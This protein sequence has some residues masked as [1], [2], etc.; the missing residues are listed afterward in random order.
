M[1]ATDET[2]AETKSAPAARGPA[3]RRR[4]ARPAPRRPALVTEFQSDA[5]EIEHR[6]PPRLARLTLYAVVALIATAI[7]WASVSHVDM[8]VVAQGK[9]ITTRPNLV[10]QPLE[11]SVIRDI[12]VRVGDR[13]RRGDVLATLDPT[14]SQAD[15][16]L[17]RNR[18]AAFDATI[19]RLRAELNGKVYVITDP[20]N[21]DEILQRKIF[22]QRK[23][24]YDAQIEDDD[25]QIASAQ[26]NLKTARDEEAVLVQRLDTT[27]SI[28][29]MRT[30][31]MNKEIGSK[32]NFLLSRDARLEVESNL[33]RIRGNIADD[34]HRVDKARA[35]RKVFAEEFLRKA[36]EELVDT[37][38]KRNSAAEDLKK[39]ELRRKL[40][41]LQAP[42]DATVLQ[43]ADRT[44]GS[45][46]REAETLFVLVPRDATLQAEV[47]VQ[48]RDIG[49][50][51]VG[52]S[53]RIKFEAFPF[54]KYGTAAGEVRVISED[55]FSPDPK[56]ETGRRDAAPY[57]RVLI[58]LKDTRLRAP[59][60]RAPL[61]PGMAVTAEMKVG[62]R[63]VISYFLY[64]LMRGLDESIREY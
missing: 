30:T 31:L 5:I 62:R 27:R 15:Q 20:A 2:R 47:N 53:A 36:Y 23:S 16:D 4:R 17:L 9:L 55:A 45:V 60:G 14:F 49:Q 13:V 39:A 58:D 26:A 51:S 37:L 50:V 59:E 54:Q 44:V 6:P 43:I 40:I 61:L 41:V 63:S 28:E 33:A 21:S 19:D 46:A 56:A 22:L 35:D 48:G 29:T 7:G 18:V 10:V 11:T 1:S 64:P 3:E 57:Y 32:L 8:I 25:A 52:Q 34:S 42:A 38:T 24:A 12:R